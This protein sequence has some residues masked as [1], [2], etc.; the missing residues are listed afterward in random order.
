M[1]QSKPFIGG[2]GAAFIGAAIGIAIA[3]VLSGCITPTLEFRSEYGNLRYSA[4][5][6]VVSYE[7]P[8]ERGLRK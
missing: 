6:N 1:N 7:L 2:V 3:I 8:S 5:K 4:G